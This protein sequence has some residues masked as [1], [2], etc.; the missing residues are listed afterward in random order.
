MTVLRNWFNKEGAIAYLI[1]GSCLLAIILVAIA[2]PV[3]LGF[4]EGETAKGFLQKP[5]WYLFPLF[6]PPVAWL[7]FVTWHRYMN[8]WK[9]LRNNCVLHT[10]NYRRINQESLGKLLRKLVQARVISLNFFP[11][12]WHWSFST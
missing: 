8:A 5:N 2:A 4:A 9:E 10:P 11:C 6:F 12:N 3:G 1:A 7:V